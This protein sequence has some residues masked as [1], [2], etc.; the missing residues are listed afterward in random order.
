MNYLYENVVT[1]P[2]L[3]GI[4]TD[5]AA[6]AMVDKNI[7]GCRWDED[8]EILLVVWQNELSADDKNILDGI[9][10]AHS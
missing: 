10:A 1:E 3:N 5:V 9:V 6:S 8:S 4:H 7:G 2:D